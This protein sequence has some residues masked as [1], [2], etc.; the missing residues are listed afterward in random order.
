M[1]TSSLIAKGKPSKGKVDL[2]S[3]YF[4][5]D[6]FASFNA[7]SKRKKL[8]ALIF[9]FTFSILFIVSFNSS[10]GD[11]DLFLNFSSASEADK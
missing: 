6:F 8:K 5:S 4:N 10:T 7:S 9:G 2:S 11:K 3:V 1:L